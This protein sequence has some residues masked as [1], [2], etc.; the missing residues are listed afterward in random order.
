M[1]TEWLR[2]VTFGV[3]GNNI[4]GVYTRS[5]AGALSQT[6]AQSEFLRPKALKYTC[7]VELLTLLDIKENH[8][9]ITLILGNI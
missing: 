9:R 2:D 6:E 5:F 4:K 1:Q 8:D 3:N 7:A